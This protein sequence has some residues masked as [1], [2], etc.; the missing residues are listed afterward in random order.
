MRVRTAGHQADSRQ[1]GCVVT[2]RHKCGT[3]A[4]CCVQTPGGDDRSSGASVAE[5]DAEA[6]AAARLCQKWKGLGREKRE[7]KTAQMYC[8]VQ[9]GQL[10]GPI[11]S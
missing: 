9:L 2:F 7:L 11:P 8:E 5:T 10:L 4:L 3:G 1:G 6:F